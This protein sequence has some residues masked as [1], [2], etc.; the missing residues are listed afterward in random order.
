LS[1]NSDYAIERG[2][3]GVLKKD[4][5]GDFDSLY[6]V[7]NHICRFDLGKDA[8]LQVAVNIESIDAESGTRVF[9]MNGVNWVFTFVRPLKTQTPPI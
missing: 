7:L 4:T 6:N 8:V 9:G 1:G 3:L 2:G 5:I